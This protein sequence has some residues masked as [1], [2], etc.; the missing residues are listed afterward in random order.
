MA[1]SDRWSLRDILSIPLEATLN[2]AI[3]RA[4]LTV[5]SHATEVAIAAAANVCP[6]AASEA[7]NRIQD[8]LARNGIHGDSAKSIAA[9][10]RRNCPEPDSNERLNPH[11]L[12]SV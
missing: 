3:D 5:I 2:T 7:A 9:Q 6:G 11:V 10:I 4:D 1:V 12:L 8:W